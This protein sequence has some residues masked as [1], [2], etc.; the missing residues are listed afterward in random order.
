VAADTPSARNPIRSADMGWLCAENPD[1]YVRAVAELIDD[2]G[3][4]QGLGT[5][6]AQRSQDF[7]WPDTLEAVARTYAE[8]VWSG[9]NPGMSAVALPTGEASRPARRLLPGMWTG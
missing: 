8:A 6:A 5:A 1:E 2:Q 3:A 9:S 7:G 4:R